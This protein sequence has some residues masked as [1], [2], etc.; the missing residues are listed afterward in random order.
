MSRYKIEPRE[1]LDTVQRIMN[2]IESIQQ[3]AER[4][5]V[6]FSSVQRGCIE[7]VL[8]RITFEQNTQLVLVYNYGHEKLN[9]L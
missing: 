3:A 5:G 6:V 4:L 2:G 1:K 9:N 8:L 7:E